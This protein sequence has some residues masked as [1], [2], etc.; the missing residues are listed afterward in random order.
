MS[1]SSVETRY[2]P[3]DSLPISS[4]F[5]AAC[6]SRGDKKQQAKRERRTTSRSLTLH[7]HLLFVFTTFRYSLHIV[8]KERAI[9]KLQTS[10]RRASHVLPSFELGR[11][12]A[13]SHPHPFPPPSEGE[14]WGEGVCQGQDS[15]SSFAGAAG[16]MILV[17]DFD[18][19]DSDFE[20]SA[21]LP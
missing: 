4:V 6:P 10:P 12:C 19:R 21:I 5:A 13:Q 17:S 2:Q 1:R 15:F 3:N 20:G 7:K 14:G 18:I 16:G 9:E 8:T 11:K